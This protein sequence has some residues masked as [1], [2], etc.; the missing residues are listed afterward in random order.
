MSILKIHNRKLRLSKSEQGM[1][2]RSL[3]DL[4]SRSSKQHNKE[5]SERFRRRRRFGNMLEAELRRV[6]FDVERLRRFARLEHGRLD[7]AFEARVKARLKGFRERGGRRRGARPEAVL[8][9]TSGY[10]NPPY[11]FTWTHHDIIGPNVYGYFS[12]TANPNT[13]YLGV[14]A[15][16]R[17]SRPRQVDSFAGLGFWFTPIEWGFSV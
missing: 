13:G 3:R 11:D 17:A 10:A 4:V 12:H 9:L 16:A 6:G 8:G 2:E 1:L 15:R 7:K 14:R 5:L